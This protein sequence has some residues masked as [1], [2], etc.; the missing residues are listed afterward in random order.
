[1]DLSSE[2]HKCD[3]ILSTIWSAKK[4]ETK[5]KKEVYVSYVT[6]Y[7]SSLSFP[8]CLNN[9]S[10]GDPSLLSFALLSFIGI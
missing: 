1:M 3:I 10:N 7:P 4:K 6:P 9:L 5:S 8:K 2:T